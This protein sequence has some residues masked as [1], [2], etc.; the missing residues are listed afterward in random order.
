MELGENSNEDLSKIGSEG[1][2]GDRLN[3]PL[4]KFREV[5]EDFRADER[6]SVFFLVLFLLLG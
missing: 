5:G 3:E 2:D 1:A 6:F 4:A